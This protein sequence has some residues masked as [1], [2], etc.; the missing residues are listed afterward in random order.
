MTVYSI[1]LFE[2]WKNNANSRYLMHS[3]FRKQYFF[4]VIISKVLQ[5][6]EINSY[7]YFWETAI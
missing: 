4:R 3:T 6:F 1:F 7:K 2:G 5:A